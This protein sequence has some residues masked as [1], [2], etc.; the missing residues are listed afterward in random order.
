MKIGDEGQTIQVRIPPKQDGISRMYHR[1]RRGQDRPSQDT[2]HLGLDDP[3]ENKGNPMLP[4]LLQLLPMI[5]RRVLHDCQTTIC[6][7]KKAMH[8]QLGM[9]RQRTASLRG[10]K[11]QTHHGTSTSRLQP[12]RTDQNRKRTPQ[13]TSVPVYYHSNAR[14]ENG[15]QLRTDPR[16]CRTP[17]CNYDRH[18]TELLAIVQAFHEWKRYT[19]GNSKP[20]RVLSQTVT[21]QGKLSHD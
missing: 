18:D 1:T 5:H 10:I 9:G 4:R 16:R 21:K 13:N 2:S 14:T 7:N 6:N 19:R 15:D 11:D 3:Q 17:E 12:P 8:W 20:I